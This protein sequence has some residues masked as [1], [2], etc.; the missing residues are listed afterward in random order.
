MDSLHF[1]DSTCSIALVAQQDNWYFLNYN[2]DEIIF[3][4]SECEPLLVNNACT[5]CKSVHIKY[6]FQIS[7]AAKW[8]CFFIC[9]IWNLCCLFT[10]ES[11]TFY[12]RSLNMRFCLKNQ[13]NVCNWIVLFVLLGFFFSFFSF[14]R[15]PFLLEI[16]II[17]RNIF[18]SLEDREILHQFL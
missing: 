12:C 6:S 2:Q 17:R 11:T 9:C 1:R 10:W 13:S 8:F 4:H 5:V 15:E 7:T 14:C 3:F 16:W 18:L